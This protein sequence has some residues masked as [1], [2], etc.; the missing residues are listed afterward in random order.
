MYLQPGVVARQSR[1]SSSL[2]P[3]K[4]RLYL[5]EGTTHEER[6]MTRGMENLGKGEISKSK[7]VVI[8]DGD[9]KKNLMAKQIEER[10]F[11]VNS[12]LNL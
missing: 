12:S 8:V 5:S 6:N 11:G 3:Y 10:R 9:M 4:K 2:R 7:R 1:N